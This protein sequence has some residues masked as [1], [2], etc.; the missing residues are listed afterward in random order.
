MGNGEVVDSGW[1][2][3]YDKNK[4]AQKGGV[5]YGKLFESK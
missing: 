4:K 2:G 5:Y 1:A 3:C